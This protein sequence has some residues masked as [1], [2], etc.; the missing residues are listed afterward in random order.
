MAAYPISLPSFA[1]QYVLQETAPA[2]IYKGSLNKKHF[3]RMAKSY[4]MPVA[5]AMQAIEAYYP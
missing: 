1:L 4:G 3:I 2:G 5:S